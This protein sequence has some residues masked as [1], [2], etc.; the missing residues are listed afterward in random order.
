LNLVAVTLSLLFATAI[1]CLE[2][3]GN[4]KAPDDS[5][6]RKSGGEAGDKQP[7]AKE[8]TPKKPKAPGPASWP[9]FRN[10]DQQL[11]VA[12]SKLPNKLEVLWKVKTQ[13]GVVATSAIVRDRVYVPGLSGDLLCLAKKDGKQIWSY[14]SIDDPDPKQFA[15]GFKSAPRVTSDTVYV[16]D[17]DGVLHAVNR[18]DGKRRW[19]A[20][21]DAEI[22]G[23]AA[24]VGDKVIVGSHD[25]FLYCFNAKDGTLAWKFETQDRVNCSPAIVEKYTFVAGCDAHLRII[26]I[27]SGKEVGDIPLESYLIAS[28]AVMGDVLY[29]GNH[30]A[31]VLAVNWKKKQIEWRYKDPVKEFPIHASA[32]VTKKYVIVGGH[33]KQMHCID[34]ETGNGVWTFAT[35]GRI[36]SSA[37]VVGDRV[38]FGSADRHL[39]GLSIDKGEEVWNFN[40][41]QSITAGPAVGENAMVVGCEGSGGFIYC[42]GKK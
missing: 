22:A 42:F 11:G 16:G 8:T 38:F 41:S 35:K 30:G 26:D 37:V 23:C 24:V 32:A 6:A 1:G 36:D 29:V 4:S 3:K 21:T 33:D 5:N 14:R 7:D 27:E 18:A 17:E 19:K 15:P 2:S 13:D 9:S 31:E 34:R 28:P 25:N 40:A 39:Y 12:T 20:T 10:G